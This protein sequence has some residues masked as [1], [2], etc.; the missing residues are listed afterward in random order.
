[1]ACMGSSLAARC[2]GSVVLLSAT[3]EIEAL[4]ASSCVQ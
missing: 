2:V 1:M 3:H 4:C